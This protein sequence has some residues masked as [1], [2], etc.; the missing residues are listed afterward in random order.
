[1][2]RR[3]AE[4]PDLRALR[5]KLGLNAEGMSLLL[6]QGKRTWWRWEKG[7]TRREQKTGRPPIPG[8]VALLLTI[9]D[10]HPGIAREAIE[11]AG[12]WDKDEKRVVAKYRFQ[13]GP[14][15]PEMDD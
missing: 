7:E 14:G 10:Q 5:E 3:K 2:A 1:M 8:A 13:A 12:L 4:L 15:R 6:R 11:A 9:L